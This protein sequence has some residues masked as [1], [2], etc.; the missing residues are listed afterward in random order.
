MDDDELDPSIADLFAYDGGGDGAD[1]DAFAGF[2]RAESV[3]ERPSD[4][5]NVFV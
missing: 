2:G 1:A 5:T 4:A 3:A